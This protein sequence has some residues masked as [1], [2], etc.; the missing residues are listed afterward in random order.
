VGGLGE[1]AK[2]GLFQEDKMVVDV[3][4]EGLRPVEKDVKEKEK[5][6]E[7][8]GKGWCRRTPA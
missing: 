2:R 3:Q 5:E 4:K 1:K 7:N 8:A 6:D